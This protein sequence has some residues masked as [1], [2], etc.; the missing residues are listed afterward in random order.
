VLLELTLIRFF[1][2]FNLNFSDF[3]LA[4]VIW[5]LG[6]C[7]VI[8]AAFIRLSPSIVGIIGL[9]IIF[10]QQLFHYVP[11]LLPGGWRPAFGR[12]WEFIYPADLEGLPGIAILYV[13]VPWIG[14][15]M[16]GYGFGK[17][18]AL[19]AA[20][21]RRNCLGIG[22]SA[23]FIFLIAASLVILLGPAPENPRPFIFRLLNQQKY[24]ASQLFLLMTL[25][26][27]IALVPWA[28]KT[29]GWF[30][31]VLKIFG[32]VPMF[33]YL[34]HILLIHLSA[35][36]VNMIRL[37]NAHQEWYNSA[38]LTQVPEDQRWGLPLLYLVFILDVILLYFA[39]RW[40]ARYKSVHPGTKWLK[41][42]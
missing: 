17:I 5:M 18:L 31:R 36:A 11:S 22:W 12:F 27:L 14:V 19:D 35:L 40:Y 20:T 23:I 10:F 26:P 34:L 9:G 13:L 4:G 41:Y 42:I 39:C 21:R 28:E 2:M 3:M 32:Q 29:N 24:P 25:G 33:Y 8:L 15:M 1:W 16:A 6:W 30:S 37:G 7:M 38:P